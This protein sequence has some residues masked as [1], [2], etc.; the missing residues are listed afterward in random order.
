[1]KA[2]FTYDGKTYNN[3]NKIKFVQGAFGFDIVFLIT[4]DADVVVDLSGKIVSL[5][6]KDIAGT[7]S[8]DIT[9]TPAVDPTTGI[10][11][12]SVASTDLDTHSVFDTEITISEG[13]LSEYKFNIGLLT[14]TQ[15]I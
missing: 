4:N 3:F 6:L 10:A 9:L 14:I 15:E 5:Q 1:M 7:T 11:T 8:K 13:V 12:W 2:T